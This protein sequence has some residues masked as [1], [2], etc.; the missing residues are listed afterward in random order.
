MRRSEREI[1]D[2]VAIEAILKAGEMCTL[3]LIDGTEPYLVP[4]NYGYRDGVL[5]FHCATEGR[6]LDILKRNPRICF[7]IVLDNRMVRD[8]DFS[9][10][11]S[12]YRSV[13]GWGSVEMVRTNEEKIEGLDVLKEHAGFSEE[14]DYPERALKRV[15]V[16]RVVIERL[17]GKQNV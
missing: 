4:M 9:K 7:S 14:Y 8:E 12:L 10:Y 3:G 17:T 5:W 16:F 1:K 11:T 13:T 6:K 15:V 2:P